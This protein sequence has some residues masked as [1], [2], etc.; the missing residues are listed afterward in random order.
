M[1]KD[2]ADAPVTKAGDKRKAPGA[3]RLKTQRARVNYPSLCVG[4]AKQG[5]L[6]GNATG[7][8]GCDLMQTDGAGN[9]G[10]SMGSDCSRPPQ[11]SFLPPSVGQ[12][13]WGVKVFKCQLLEEFHGRLWGWGKGSGFY[14]LPK[15]RG[16]SVW[17]ACLPAESG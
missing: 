17:M 8:A 15:E 9:P 11:P 5:E 13:L 16:I 1:M 14:E 3:L 6:R 2:M 4:S 7:P 12:D 10:S